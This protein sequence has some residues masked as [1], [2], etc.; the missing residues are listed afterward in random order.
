MIRKFCRV[1]PF[2]CAALLLLSGCRS[3]EQRTLSVF[4]WGEYI[5]M[6]V[7]D[8]FE[9]ETGIKVI[10]S[11]F[12]TNE[13][14]YLKLTSGGSNYDLLVP[15][16]Y[17]IERLIKED[18]LAK[19]DFNN[20]PNYVLISSHY[21]N[22]DFDPDNEYSVPYMWGTLGILYNTRTVSEIPTWDSLWDSRYADAIIMSDSVRDSFTPALKRLGY[23]CN[24]TN[25][26]H[27]R[28]AL[29]SLLAQSPL[30]YGYYV[31]QTKDQMAAENA[32]LALVY[33][34][35]ALTA[36][37]M[38]EDL[39]YTVPSNSNLWF[40]SLVV[41]ANAL[42]KEEAEM[43][44]NFLCRSDIAIKNMWEIGYSTPSED[45]LQYLDP[46]QTSAEE[47]A[48]LLDWDL[49]DAQEILD[50]NL[51]DNEVMFPEESVYGDCEVFLDLGSANALYDAL[52][53]ELKASIVG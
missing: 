23:S 31:D 41:P 51:L 4:N 37:S 6:D 42:H 43:F 28:E 38:N 3:T 26:E 49:E 50:E 10:Y 14:M 8:Q 30:V 52:W 17:M 7:I 12:E 22:L 24:E 13:E 19:L 32:D 53:T 44:I 11:L 47:L 35:D 34:G 45:A 39:A 18:R 33:S 40:D 16:D 36:M 15:S 9:E 27:L 25:A 1:L 48:S 46:E 20:I 5:D 21:K 29:A 2:F